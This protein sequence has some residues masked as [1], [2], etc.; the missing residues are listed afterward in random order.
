MSPQDPKEIA[1][2]WLTVQRHWWA[3]E[4]VCHL[5]KSQPHEALGLVLELVNMADSSELLEDVGAGPLEDL[6]RA[7]GSKVI[8][9]IEA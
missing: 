3:Y 9:Q 6:L 4:A 1:R 8:H 2:S 7:H 5:C